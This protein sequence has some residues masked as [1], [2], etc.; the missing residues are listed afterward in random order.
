M[1]ACILHKNSFVSYPYPY[2]RDLYDGLF[3]DVSQM[4][5]M[6]GFEH[7]VAIS[8]AVWRQCV[9]WTSMDTTMVGIY[10]NEERR[11]NHILT[12]L[13]N[14]LEVYYREHCES[15]AFAVRMVLKNIKFPILE[16]QFLQLN[17]RVTTY[18][19]EGEAVLAI[20]LAS[21]AL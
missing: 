13:K 20:I 15:N 5:E 9:Q 10:Q 21:E 12:T 7:K 11:L 17:F 4:A 2:F 18:G 1:L 6:L 14:V 8:R 3:I 16:P 19:E